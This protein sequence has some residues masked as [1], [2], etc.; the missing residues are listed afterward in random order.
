VLPAANQTPPPP[1]PFPL[2]IVAVLPSIVL[3]RMFR[4]PLDS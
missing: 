4:E 3:L 2:E 1:F